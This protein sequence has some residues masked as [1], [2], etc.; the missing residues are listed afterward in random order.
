MFIKNGFITFLN[1]PILGIGLSNSGLITSLVINEATYLHCNYVELLACT[2]LIGFLFYYIIY[3]IN[4]AKSIKIRNDS[5]MTEFVSII[6]I[7]MLIADISCVTYYEIKTAMY[8]ILIF[9]LLDKKNWK[10]DC[11]EEQ[12]RKIV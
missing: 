8:L 2:G 10:E 5:K 9:I 11:N 7:V 3:I 6:I 4:L 1:H 12:K